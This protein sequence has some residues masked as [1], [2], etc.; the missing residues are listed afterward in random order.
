MIDIDSLSFSYK[1]RNI[2]ENISFSF[3]SP[4]K[5]LIV[6]DNASGKSTFLNLLSGFLIFED[7]DIRIDNI[8]I[9]KKF[10]NL[11]KIRSLMA[12]LPEN[13]KLNNNFKVF[14]IINFYKLKRNLIF[15]LLELDEDLNFQNLSEAYKYRL[16][17][18]LVLKYKKYLL[19][20]DLMK[21]QDQNN[22]IVRII[23]EFCN[24]QTLIVTSPS[25]ISGINWDDVLIIKEGRFVNA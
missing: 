8:S 16:L 25:K 12:Y 10:L 19:I 21:F 14:D 9:K 22:N 20:D 1:E 7:G 5:Y 11:D 6:G 17:I 23:N 4:G 24:G 2:F 3:K 18:F 13:I 15:D